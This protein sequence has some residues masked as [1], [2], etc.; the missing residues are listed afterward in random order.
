MSYG[1]HKMVKF[2]RIYGQQCETD[3]ID[4]NYPK[5]I[6]TA[7]LSIAY[8]ILKEKP[9]ADV[10]ITWLLPRDKEISHRRK[11]IQIVNKMLKN[12]HQGN[13]IVNVKF[14]KPD[15]DWVE[16][17]SHL[18]PNLYFRNFLHLNEKGNIK[19]AKKIGNSLRIHKHMLPHTTL[20][21]PPT[22]ITTNPTPNLTTT[23]TLAPPCAPPKPTPPSTVPPV[24]SIPPTSPCPTA[25]L[26]QPPAIS[27]SSLLQPPPNPS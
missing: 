3:N 11:R 15:T 23:P 26:S 18:S 19:F 25:P 16:E 13:K 14:L 20:L 9:Q 5:D 7:I 4:K 2:L 8:F 21:I 10:T 27:F 12:W 1:D 17:N 22:Q 24:P 6:K